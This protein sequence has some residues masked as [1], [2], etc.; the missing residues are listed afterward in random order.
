M[1]SN[2]LINTFSV[3]IPTHN[4][5]S[6][7]DNAL[8]SV[9][10]QNRKPD[11]VIIVDDGSKDDTILYIQNHFMSLFLKKNIKL[12][13]ISNGH[14]GPGKTRNDGIKASNSEWICFLDSD[15]EW[16][17]H[18]IK[19]IEKAI[20]EDRNINFFCHYEKFI[21]LDGRIKINEYGKNYNKNKSLISQ[22][23]LKNFFSTSSVV[24]KKNL[25]VNHGYF[26]ETLMSSQDY[27]LW[28]KLSPFIKHR[29]IKSVLGSYRERS[30]NI[31]SG[32]IY[33]RFINELRIMYYYR[34]SASISLIIKK[35]IR[36]CL[37]YSYYSIIRLINQ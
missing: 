3:V 9:L 20:E 14:F 36:L 24:V 32:R 30:G 2:I 12:N 7:I 16:H 27:D 35:F 31:T 6:F 22:L 33:K 34:K 5:V 8:N 23:Y 15:D 18:K 13:L 28:L 4:S 29:F 25:L 26:S 11:E 37:A 1:Q 17:S 10:S 21:K 19:E